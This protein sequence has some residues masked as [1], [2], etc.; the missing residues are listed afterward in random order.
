[1]RLKKIREPSFLH[2]RK[3]LSSGKIDPLKLFRN[4]RLKNGTLGNYILTKWLVDE[5]ID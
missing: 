1:M 2:L 4:S 3:C 5:T